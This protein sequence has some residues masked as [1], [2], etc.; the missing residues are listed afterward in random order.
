MKFTFWA[1]FVDDYLLLR[2]GVLFNGP[3]L[4][5]PSASRSENQ[6]ALATAALNVLFYRVIADILR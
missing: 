3:V 6:T 1:R 4:A 5:A 2:R